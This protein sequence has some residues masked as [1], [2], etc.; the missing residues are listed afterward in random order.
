MAL[1]GSRPLPPCSIRRRREETPSKQKLARGLFKMADLKPCMQCKPN[2]TYT[3]DNSEFGAGKRRNEFVAQKMA[4]GMALG[5]T[6]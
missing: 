6:Y 5:L 1:N 4:R 2:P 3:K